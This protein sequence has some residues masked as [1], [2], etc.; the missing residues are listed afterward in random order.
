MHTARIS[1]SFFILCISV[2]GYGQDIWMP[3]R[4]FQVESRKAWAEHLDGDKHAFYKLQATPL[5]DLI[6]QAPVEDLR[7]TTSLNF[8]QGKEIP[9]PLPDGNIEHYRVMESSVMEEGIRLRYPSIKSFKGVSVKNPLHII[10][11]DIGPYGFHGL[12]ATEDGMIQIDPVNRDNDGHYIAYYTDDYQSDAYEGMP[13]CGADHSTDQNRPA[14]K[15]GFSRNGTAPNF[16]RVYRLAMSCTSTW[17]ASRGTLEKC[18]ADM[19]TMVNRAN[20]I[21]ERELA[22][23]MVLVEKNDRVIF[24]TSAEDPFTS[25]DQGRQLI[26]QNTGVLNQRIGSNFYD[27]GHVL[28]RCFDVGGIASLGS[29]CSGGKGAGVTCHNNNNIESIVTRVLS[30]EMGHQMSASHTF[31]R[32][33]ETDQLALGTAYEPGSGSTI[34]SYAGGCGSDNLVSN[35]DDYY[36]VASL[37][38]MLSYTNWEQSDAFICA[39]KV[40]I[41]NTVPD[42][43]IPLND[44]FFIPVSTPFELTA[45]AADLEKDSLTYVWEQYDNGGSNPL[46][47]PVGNVPVFRSIRP[48]PNPTRFFP[49]ESRIIANRLTEIDELMPTYSRQFNFRCTV[50]DNH[51]MGGAANWD[52]VRF[53]VT[54]AAGPFKITYPRLDAKLKVGQK[55]AVTWDVANTDKAPVNCKRVNIYVSVDGELRTGFPNL[56]PLALNVDN[57]GSEDVIIPNI[58]STRVRFVIK[59]ADNIFLTSGILP[60]TISAP[61]E[62]AFFMQVND[63]VKATCLPDPVSFEFITEGF[64]GIDVPVNFEVISGLPDGAIATFSA[65]QINAGQNTILTLNLDQV[66]GTNSYT[67]VVRSYAEG[68]DTLERKLYLSLTGTDLDN[69]QGFSPENGLSGASSLQKFVWSSKKDA[70]KYEFQLAKNP[71]FRA[72]D[73]VITRETADTFFLSTKILDKSTIYYWRVRSSNNCRNGSW[74]DVRA[75]NTEA[76]SCFT[77]GSGELSLN[78]SGS[79]TPSVEGSLIVPQNVVINDINIKKVRGDHQRVGDVQAILK[80]PDGTELL[81]WSQRCSTS[82][83]FNIGLDDESSDF[84]QCPINTLRIYRPV[85]PLSFFHGKSSQGI[86]KMRIED[87]V[88]GEGGRFNEFELEICTNITLD[89]PFLV[90]KNPVQLKPLESKVIQETG[91][92]VN[93]NNNTPSELIFT[94]VAVPSSGLLLLNGEPLEPGRQFTQALINQGQLVY[95]HLGNQASRDNFTFTVSDGQGG[96]IPVTEFEIIIDQSSSVDNEAQN[97]TAFH[98]YPNPFYNQIGIYFSGGTISG[99]V[100]YILSDLNGKII[101]SGNTSPNENITVENVTPGVYI[102]SLLHSNRRENFKLIKI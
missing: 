67:I 15:F 10:R 69:L 22:V 51:P 72:Q 43:T 91:L 21:Y 17:A 54:D 48:R 46:G 99:N 24:L 71:G 42:I 14:L 74:L 7:S 8:T 36:H 68:I 60:S 83:G 49:N 77:A 52:Q 19:N 1:F 34:M 30:H 50:R 35:N 57:D 18:L 59:A 4:S 81:L 82:K 39:E 80:A 28:S 102:L 40:D 101:N 53:N 62:P 84:F 97:I 94:L 61:T 3:A 44:G 70:V 5:L 65:P 20:L 66:R 31:N 37:D 41:G 85:N 11:F 63:N 13:L 73:M 25:T 79:G 9:V 23:R 12:I 95:K 6:S 76:S 88:P 96:W 29:I 32:C 64:G 56:I 27:I 58:I 89:P 38:Q 90:N 78:I 16:L 87:K 75:F 26:G 2:L 45:N 98:I 93:D 47:A 92:L 86:W 100:N 33:G 55:I